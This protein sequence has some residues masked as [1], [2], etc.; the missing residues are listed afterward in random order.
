MNKYKTAAL[1]Q[2]NILKVLYFFMFQ[3]ILHL[4][5]S[6]GILGFTCKHHSEQVFWIRVKYLNTKCRKKASVS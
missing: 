3:M 6:K 5:S 2:K 4:K 1:K